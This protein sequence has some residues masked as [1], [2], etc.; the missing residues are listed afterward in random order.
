MHRDRDL[1][2]ILKGASKPVWKQVHHALN[3]NVAGKS[4]AVFQQPLANK[5]HPV[6]RGIA[7]ILWDGGRWLPEITGKER[8]LDVVQRVQESGERCHCLDPF[9]IGLQ[10]PE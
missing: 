10:E 1:G 6:P 4:V 5:T 3:I 9:R 8:H 7:I 2:P